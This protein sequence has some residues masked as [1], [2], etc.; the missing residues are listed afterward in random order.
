M[1]IQYARGDVFKVGCDEGYDF[2]LVFG[3]VGL[4]DMAVTWRD[5]RS[6]FLKQFKAVDDP[7]SSIGGPVMFS[8]GKWLQFVRE[9]ENHGMST[10]RLRQVVDAAFGWAA[11]SGLRSI[12]TNGI[13]D[14][15]HGLVPANN[16][17][18][19]DRRVRYLDELVH[20][21][22]HNFDSIKLIS[23]NDAF[24]RNLGR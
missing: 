22:E 20:G 23:L 7:F 9:E 3:H 2:I 10:Q 11:E 17:A 18:S 19:D 14:T 16:R 8:P 6:R 12:I 21:H 13:M 1:P 15:D 5:F 24:T 4:N